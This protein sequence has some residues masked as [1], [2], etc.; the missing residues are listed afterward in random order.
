M[1]SSLQRFLCRWLA[2]KRKSANSKL[3]L[4][5]LFKLLFWV[6]ESKRNKEKWTEPQR[7][8]EHHQQYQY[9]HNGNPRRIGKERKKGAERI[10]EEITTEKFPKFDENINL[11][12]QEAQLTPS[13]MNSRYPNIGT[14]DSRCP[15]NENKENFHS[16]KRN[17]IPHVQRVLSKIHSWLLIGNHK[18]Q[19]VVGCY[20]QS[21]ERKRLFKYLV[22]SQNYSSKNEGEIKT[23]IDKPNLKEQV[24]SWCAPRELLRKS[25]RV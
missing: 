18:D 2:G 16:R 17:V 4:L 23:F 9:T 22:S 1:K 25:F 11:Y 24:A 20:T 15:K 5:R 14:S 21:A 13:R 19:K 6:T 7:Q 12:T 10:S 3:G 8:V